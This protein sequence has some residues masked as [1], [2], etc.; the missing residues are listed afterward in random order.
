MKIVSVVNRSSPSS[1][2]LKAGVC[3]TFWLKFRGLM[4]QKVLDEYSGIL[5]VE[6][7]DNIVNTSIHMLFMN[8]DI[9]AIWIDSQNTIVDMKIARRW[10]P[11]YKPIAPAKYVLE[12]HPNRIS[13]FKIGDT[14]EINP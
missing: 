14:I 6:K 8:F 11:V 9:A 12:A 10:R 2:P 13:D 3:D 1:T 4:F 5:L 7:T